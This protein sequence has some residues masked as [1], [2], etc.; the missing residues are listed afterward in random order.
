[1]EHGKT[2]PIKLMCF[3]TA[4][5]NRMEYPVNKRAGKHR[6]LKH[7]PRERKLAAQK[8]S[9]CLSCLAQ[10]NNKK[11]KGAYVPK[12]IGAIAGNVC[13]NYSPLV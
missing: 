4:L 7:P 5:S 11:L 6:V 8:A 3:I 12:A 1:M 2:G 9:G 13:Q 10:R